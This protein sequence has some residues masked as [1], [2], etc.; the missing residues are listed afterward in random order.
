MSNF[1]ASECIS[2]AQKDLK[3]VYFPFLV[4]TAILF[5][6][7]WIGGKVKI[8]HLVV[9]NFLV[10]MSFVENLSLLTQIVMT[11]RFGTWRYGIPIILAWALYVL[12]NPVFSFFFKKKIAEVDIYYSKWAKNPDNTAT[13]NMLFWLGSGISWKFYKLL[14]SHF[15]GYNIKSV[16]IKDCAAIRSIQKWFLLFNSCTTYPLVLIMNFAGLID[17]DWGTQL[18]ICFIENLIIVLLLIGLGWWEQ[19]MQQK[20]YLK[21]G[22]FEPLKK[23]R[24][25]KLMTGALDTDEEINATK[26]ILLKQFK[27]N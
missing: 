5:S 11:F 9:P 7:S 19:F 13:K 15:W 2:M 24:L 16:T 26:D 17:M 12:A 18:Y 21:D 1:D 22:M 23:G 10:M 8:I 27:E 14:Y 6:L 4:L 3:V 20:K 25:T